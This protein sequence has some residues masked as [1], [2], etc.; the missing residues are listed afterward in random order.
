[1]P[2]ASAEVHAI[3][4]V[5]TAFGTGYRLVYTITMPNGGTGTLR[6]AATP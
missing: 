1:M 5:S 6:V 3:E 2:I 4:V